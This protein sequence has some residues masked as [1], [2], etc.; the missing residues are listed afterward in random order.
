MAIRRHHQLE[1]PLLHRESQVR[2]Q[3]RPISKST[4]GINKTRFLKKSYD[5]LKIQTNKKILPIF[6]ISTMLRKSR[7]KLSKVV[8]FAQSHY[9]VVI[10]NKTSKGKNLSSK[11]IIRSNY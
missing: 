2:I 4:C 11:L 8:Y 6:S 10:Q 9:F 7:L 5:R 3:P 1:E